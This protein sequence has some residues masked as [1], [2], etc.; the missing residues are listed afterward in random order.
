M[1]ESHT[2]TRTIVISVL[3][4]TSGTRVLLRTMSGSVVLLQLPLWE[5]WLHFLPFSWESWSLRQGLRRAL[6]EGDSPGK[7]PD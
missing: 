6:S 7:G 5:N 2:I 4:V 1:S 3:W